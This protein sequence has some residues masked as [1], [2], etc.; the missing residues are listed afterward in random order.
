[1]SLDR[2]VA[3]VDHLAVTGSDVA[4]EYRLETFLS[5]GH[6]PVGPPGLADF[7]RAE[8]RLID[9]KLLEKQLNLYPANSK[10]IHDKAEEQLA[11]IKKKLDTDADFQTS[12]HALGISEA[13]LL[14]RLE[15][16][17]RIMSMIDEHLRPGATVTTQEVE[18]YYQK[19]FLPQFKRQS[20]GAPPAL[21][22]VEGRIREILVQE[23]INQLFEH[24]LAELKKDA[25]VR[26]IL[27]HE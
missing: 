16:Q 24:W 22:E 1:M 19:T 20:E 11:Q 9:Q 6:V 7:D 17:Q 13:Q 8:S 23:K 4:K 12:L 26:I 25:Q 5:R 21:R 3:S 10:L 2:V 15:E 27:P 14:K 18:T